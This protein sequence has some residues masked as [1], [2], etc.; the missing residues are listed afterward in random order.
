MKQI[1]IYIEKMN[2]LDFIPRINQAELIINNE[3]LVFIVFKTFCSSKKSYAHK[4]CI[5]VAS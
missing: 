2:M 3:F 5:G 4:T 1:D